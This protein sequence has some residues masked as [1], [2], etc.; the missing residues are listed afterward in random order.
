MQA[1]IARLSAL[2]TTLIVGS[3]FEDLHTSN[4]QSVTMI[5]LPNEH[6]AHYH[7]ISMQQHAHLGVLSLSATALEGYSDMHFEKDSFSKSVS[8]SNLESTPLATYYCVHC[9]LHIICYVKCR[10][11][12][13]VVS[14]RWY[15]QQQQHEVRRGWLFLRVLVE[16]G[17]NDSPQERSSK[18]YH[19]FWFQRTFQKQPPAY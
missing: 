1:T 8:S 14:C 15:R 10:A 17:W 2:S 7:R 16:T 19:S 3:T 18:M 5:T 11:A 9:S 4:M 6:V 12:D 13:I